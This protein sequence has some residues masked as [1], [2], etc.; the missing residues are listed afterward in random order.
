M[1][2]WLLNSTDPSIGADRRNEQYWGDVIETYNQTTPG[3][4]RRN[5]KQAKD[6]CHKI[7][8]W[9][10]LFHNAWLKARRVFTSGYN[11]QMWIDKAHHFYVVDNEDLGHFVLMDVWYA[12]RNEAK[13]VTYNLGLKEARKRKVSGKEAGEDVEHAGAEE[14]AERPRPMGQKQAKKVARDI[15][16]N[17]KLSDNDI[18]EI[19]TFGKIQSEEHANRLK[20]LEVQQK[21]SSD[22]LESAKIAHLAAKE[23]KEAKKN[24]KLKL[25]CLRHI[26]VFSHKTQD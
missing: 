24:M 8:R 9:T 15:K 20:V 2:S 12:V 1:S 18:E 17:S 14:H 4:R 25:G 19:Q 16:A 21:L 6:R 13:W 5:Q 7:N 23:Q 10:N 11:D 22:T 3:N 26:T